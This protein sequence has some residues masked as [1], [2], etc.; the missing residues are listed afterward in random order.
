MLAK[1]PGVR[2]YSL[3]KGGAAAEVKT[4]PP[5][6]DLSD[7]AGE[8]KSFADTAA[9]VANLDLVISVDT[10]VAHLAGA[11]G[12]PIWLMIPHVADWRWMEHR[13][14]SPWYPTARLFRQA[15]AGDWEG[16]ACRVRDELWT[17]SSRRQLKG[18]HELVLL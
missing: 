12:K 2:F 5:G 9:L 3:Q 10:S 15:S 14:D 11:M 18:N 17:Q 4:R 7:F 8:L 1:V 16:L 6:M 13:D